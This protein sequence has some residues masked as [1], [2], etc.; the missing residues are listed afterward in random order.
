MRDSLARRSFKSSRGRGKPRTDKPNSLKVQSFPNYFEMAAAARGLRD[1]NMQRASVRRTTGRS[2]R[3][4]SQATIGRFSPV[5]R[6]GG[7]R[8]LR[9]E[10]AAALSRVTRREAISGMIGLGTA[11]WS[12]KGLRIL[13]NHPT[14][15]DAGA[16]AGDSVGRKR[17]PDRVRKTT[18]LGAKL[19]SRVPRAG[20]SGVDLRVGPICIGRARIGRVRTSIAASPRFP[21]RT[22]EEPCERAFASRATRGT[23]S[24]LP[25]PA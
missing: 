17:S 2:R 10:H 16:S 22:V 5:A 7:V 6:R 13:T 12:W 20:E 9:P 15:P 8:R 14:E 11:G 4:R 19:P 23:V 24:L 21:L 25:V 18:T 1:P 3:T